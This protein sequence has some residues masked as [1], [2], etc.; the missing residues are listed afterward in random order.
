MSSR[1]RQSGGRN[2]SRSRESSDDS[3]LTDDE[4]RMVQRLFSDPF[5]FPIQ[6]KTWLPSYIETAGVTLP[7]SSI[8]GLQGRLKNLETP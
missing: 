3:P 6:F 7:Q 5:S 4:Y 8:V 1:A 2:V